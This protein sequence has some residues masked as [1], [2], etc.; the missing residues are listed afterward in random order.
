MAIIAIIPSTE[1]GVGVI[2]ADIHIQ[3]ND[4]LSTVL[5]ASYLVGQ[6]FVFNN[7]Q[8]AK[9]YTTDGVYEL[10]VNTSGANPVLVPLN[11]IPVA[12][13]ISTPT[14]SGSTTAAQLSTTRDA[15]VSY[16][17]NGTVTISLLAGQSITATLRYADNSGMST[18]VVTVDIAMTSNSGVLGLT[19]VNS[20]KLSGVIPAGKY[21]Q[22]TFSVAGGA[23]APT[24]IAAGQEVLI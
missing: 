17:Y 10:G 1:W 4:S 18:N 8:L 3:T 12:L 5:G 24:A 7:A 20:L 9:V 13:G 19:Q 23:T 16:T 15:M 6:T 2:P 14:F 22:V 11:R 21:R